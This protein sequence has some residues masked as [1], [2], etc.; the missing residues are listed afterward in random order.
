MT[1]D[2][3]LGD[4]CISKVAERLGYDSLATEYKKRSENYKNLFDKETGFIRPKDSQGNF[5]SDFDPYSWGQDYTEGSAWQ[6]SLFVPHDIDG[7]AKLM[8]GK[9]ALLERLD[10]TL[11]AK[12]KYRVGGYGCEIHEMTEMAQA[13]FGQVAISNQPSFHIPYMYAYLG[14]KEKARRL[15]GDLCCLFTENTFPGDEDNGSMSAWYI[16]AKLGKYSLCPDNFIQL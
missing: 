3:A 2:F 4:Y 14:K 10:K 5:K 12:P 1:L 6:T 15:I 7:L 11:E 13:D 9:K 16:L 8:G